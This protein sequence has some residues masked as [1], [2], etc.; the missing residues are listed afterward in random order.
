MNTMCSAC[1]FASKSCQESKRGTRREVRATRHSLFVGAHEIIRASIWRAICR[2][3][4]V[5]SLTNGIIRPNAAC[6]KP[7]YSKK[8]GTSACYFTTKSFKQTRSQVPGGVM[9][10]KSCDSRIVVWNVIRK[11]IRYAG[12]APTLLLTCYGG[13]AQVFYPTVVA[14]GPVAPGAGAGAAALPIAPASTTGIVTTAQAPKPLDG[15]GFGAGLALSIGQSRANS[16][17]AVGP[18]NIVRVT[19]S[20]SALAGVVFESHCFFVPPALTPRLSVTDNLGTWATYCSRCEH[21]QHE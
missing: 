19:D 6:R 4:L 8:A 17:V 1:R 12:F 7:P 2:T 20:S 5:V 3:R 21:E 11:G 13:F 10:S 9:G 15:L 18:N 14:P 16:A